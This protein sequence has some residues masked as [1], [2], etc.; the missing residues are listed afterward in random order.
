MFVAAA[1]AVCF[2]P[3][4]FVPGLAS[5]APVASVLTGPAAAPEAAPSDSVRIAMRRETLPPGGKLP[6]HRAEGERY[7][8][9]LSGK[10]KV[11][12][13]VTGDEQIVEAGKMAAE[14]PGDWHIAQALGSDPVTLYVIDRTPAAAAPATASAQ[15]GGGGN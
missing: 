13:L 14:Q 8:F 9:V 7:L 4:L 5:A 1:L 12:D 3:G 2:V 15:A 6:E 11:S 10:L